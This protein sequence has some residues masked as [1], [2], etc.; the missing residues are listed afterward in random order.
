MELDFSGYFGLDKVIWLNTAHQGALPLRAAEAVKQV[1]DRKVTL[2]DLSIESFAEVPTRLRAAM[3]RL[4]GGRED[5]IALANSASYGLHVIANSFPWEK[6]DEVIVMATDFPSDVLPWLMLEQRFGV[7][8]RRLRPR[9]KVISADELR[10]AITPKTRLFCTTWVHSFSGHVIDLEAIGDICRAHNVIFVLNGSQ[11]VGA[12]CV[13]VSQYPIDALT[14]VGF[15]WLCGPYGTGFCW[16][17]PR[18]LDRLQRT[19]SYWLSMLSPAD[20]AGDLGDLTIGP[21]TSASEFDIFGTANFFNFVPFTVA[22][23]LLLELGL[24][25]IETYDQML[26]QLLV[27]AVARTNFDLISA[28]DFSVRRSTLVLLGSPQVERLTALARRLHGAG[29]HTAMR[30]GAIR[31]SPHLYNTPAQIIEV[32]E[33]LASA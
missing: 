29:I 2:A 24:K 28:P 19:K 4:I 18:L 32:A 26:V 22:I 7:R 27:E 16:F 13:D 6:G 23:E 11:A 9:G 10:A 15:K 21:L 5:E 17:A 12:R 31:I 33:M 20:L 8:I 14:S 30:A 25:R 1:V 3:A